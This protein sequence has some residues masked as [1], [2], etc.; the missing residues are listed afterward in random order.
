MSKYPQRIILNNPE[1]KVPD[2]IV[3]QFF[4]AIKTANIDTIRNFALK[5]KNKYNL[6]ERSKGAKDN[7]GNSNKNPFHAVMELDDKVADDDTKLR[8]GDRQR[9]RRQHDSDPLAILVRGHEPGT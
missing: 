3:E 6:L 8:V 2:D 4:M 1:K 5:Y 7:T 9:R